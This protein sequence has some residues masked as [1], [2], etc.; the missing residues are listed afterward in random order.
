MGSLGPDTHAT[1]VGYMGVSTLAEVSGRLMAAGMSGT[2][3]AAVIEQGTLLA[4][5]RCA[6]RWPRSQKVCRDQRD[7]ASAIFV[8]R[9]GRGAREGAGIPH[10]AT[11]A[12]RPVWHV[13]PTFGTERGTARRGRGGAL[14]AS[15]ADCG[16]AFGAGAAPL[17][18][19]I[20]QSVPELDALERERAA[21]GLLATITVWCLG[22]ATASLARSRAG[23]RSKTSVMARSPSELVA[24][25][26][27]D[28]DRTTSGQAETL[29]ATQDTF[30]YTGHRRGTCAI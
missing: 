10:P 12:R 15:A 13:R 4:N 28:L 26:R 22:S 21:H 16:G 8:N 27:Q 9:T 24:R 3:P 11:A 7:Q 5:A 29:E 17:S 1:L 30:F 18:G 23:P 25:L 6:R 20:V 19:W 2:M 14:G